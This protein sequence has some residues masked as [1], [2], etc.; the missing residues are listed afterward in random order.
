MLS[1][2]LS[3]EK[4]FQ[5]LIPSVLEGRIGKKQSQQFSFGENL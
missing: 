4:G 5:F 2:L 3:F 1:A